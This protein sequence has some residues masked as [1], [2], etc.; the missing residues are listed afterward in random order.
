VLLVHLGLQF[1]FVQNVR[2]LPPS[3]SVNCHDIETEHIR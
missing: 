2:L 1:Y 3:R